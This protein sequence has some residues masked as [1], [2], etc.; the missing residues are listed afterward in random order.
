MV[1]VH[2][3]VFN[4]CLSNVLAEFDSINIICDKKSGLNILEISENDKNYPEI[5]QIMKKPGVLE[6]IHELFSNSELEQ[7]DWLYIRSTWRCAYPEP[8]DHFGFLCTTYNM[9]KSALDECSGMICRCQ[10]KQTAPFSLGKT[11]NWKTRGFTMLNCVEDEIFVSDT[12]KHLLADSQIRGLSFQCVLDKKGNV[13][14]N[15]SQII[16]NDTVDPGVDISCVQRFSV[17]PYCGNKKL[18]LK[19]G[20]LSISKTCF[21]SIQ[22]DIV[23]TSERFGEITDSRKILISHDFYKTIKQ[24][25][26]DQCLV[27]QPISLK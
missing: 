26:I 3:F 27:F 15:I 17:C 23:K 9:P 1:I 24:N 22:S 13:L 16:V 4:S 25:K 14:N 7:A 20:M 18:V 12:V 19:P 5:S 11:P 6:S 21:K 8:R 10:L 2:R